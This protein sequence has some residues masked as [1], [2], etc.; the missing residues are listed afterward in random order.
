LLL[1]NRVIGR[2]PPDKDQWHISRPFRLFIDES[3][4]PS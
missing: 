1:G 3:S 2:R 4:L